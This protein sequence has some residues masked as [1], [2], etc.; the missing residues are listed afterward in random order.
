MIAKF[1]LTTMKLEETRYYGTTDSKKIDQKWSGSSP[2]F[3][4]T[5][6]RCCRFRPPRYSEVGIRDSN[7][8]FPRILFFAT[9]WGFRIRYPGFGIRQGFGIRRDLG[10]FFVNTCFRE[11]EGFGGI[12]GL[13]FFA[14]KRGHTKPA[15][16]GTV[17]RTRNKHRNDYGRR[18]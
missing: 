7:T 2:D 8:H 11:P 5:E 4:R 10:F 3:S 16:P 18:I 14:E 6:R 12:R 1:F 9:I 15:T 17:M 13:G